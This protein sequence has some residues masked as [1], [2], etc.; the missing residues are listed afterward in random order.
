MK[1]ALANIGETE[2]SAAALR[3]EQAGR[4]QDLAAI[5]ETPAF[6]EALRVLID[7]YRPSGGD[8]TAEISG[9]DTVYLRDKL[10]EIK[11]ACETF[12]ITAARNALGDLRQKAWPHHINGS[13]D[14]ISVHLLHSAFKKAAAAAENT[15]KN[16]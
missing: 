7:K 4:K 15:T 9:D 13:L 5:E 16:T 6:I 3:L 14:E 11:T 8:E 2:L 12:E 10:L 1:S